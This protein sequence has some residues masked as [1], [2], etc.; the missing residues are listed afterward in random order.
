MRTNLL[1]LSFSPRV[2]SKSAGLAKEFVSAWHGANPGAPL[3]HHALGQTPVEGPDE[4]WIEANMT[5]EE[6]RTP[7]Q[8]QRLAASDTAIAELHE[9]SHIVIATP[10]FNFGVPWMLKTYIDLIVRVGKT[11]SFDPA[12]GFGPLLSNDKKLLIVWSSA[13]DY[14]AQT[15]AGTYDHLTPYLHHVFG[16][17]GITR[18]ETVSIGNMWG[19]PEAVEASLE[20]A[21]ARLTALST[22]W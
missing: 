11:F 19:P 9:A 12:K 2:D 20:A 22:S 15:P 14:P 1:Y 7:E 8:M 10:M 4:A 6:A 21:Q 5:R 18:T 13:G 17:M 16:F 3:R